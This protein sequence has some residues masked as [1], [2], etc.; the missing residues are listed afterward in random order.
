MPAS[1]IG[2][3]LGTRNSLV[4][5]TGKGLVLNEP[6]IVVYDKNT[7]KIRAIGEEARMMEERITSD[8]EIIRPI[9]QG[10]IVDYTVMEKML[11]YLSPVQWEGV[12]S[13]SRVSAFAFQAELQ[14][15]SVK[16]WRRLPIRPEPEM[17]LWWKSLLQQPLVPGWM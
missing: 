10:V 17:Y 14:R 16:L 15:S 9:R 11:K 2:I 8:M 5:S 3:D 6:S 12:L 4:Y 7:E 13:V 1:D